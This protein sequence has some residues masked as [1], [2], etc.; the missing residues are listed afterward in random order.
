MNL[1]R[2]KIR[3]GIVTP[4]SVED[5]SRTIHELRVFKQK[6]EFTNLQQAANVSAQA[7]VQA[8]AAACK[9]GMMEY[10]IQAKLECCFLENGCSTAYPS[11]VASGENACVLH[12]IENSRRM[13]DGDLLLI[14]A[15]GGIRLLCSRYHPNI[16]SQWKIHG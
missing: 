14:D 12:Y 11:I 5:I 3:S 6:S 13:Q 8:M 7:H 2:R 1:A 15:G 9:P 10:E 16:S 4:N